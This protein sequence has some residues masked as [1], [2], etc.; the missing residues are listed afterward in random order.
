M[1]F[2]K[3]PTRINFLALALA[4]CMASPVQAQTPLPTLADTNLQ[5]CLTEQA[6]HNGW[7]YA[8]QVV[9]FECANRAVSMLNGIEQ[10][11]RLA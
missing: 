10:L 7:F 5:N 1:P 6:A 9:K 11:S 3:I 8:E 2:S 4:A